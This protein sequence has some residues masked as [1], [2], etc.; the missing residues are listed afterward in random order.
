MPLS[1]Q[2][3][4]LPV[5]R[6]GLPHSSPSQAVA[7]LLKTTPALLAC[8]YLPRRSFREQSY[9]RSA[10]GFPGLIVDSSAERVYVQQAL[11]V[12][13]I[14]RLALAYL[15]DDAAHAALS[16]DDAAG[17]TE[18]LRS[19][20]AG[21]KGRALKSEL[22]GPISLGLQLTDE[23]QRPLAYEP[24]LLDALTQHL[25]LRAAWQ[26]AQFTGRAADSIL[27]LDEP[28]LDAFESPFCP[29]DLDLGL[30]LLEKV[31]AE[32]TGCRA[33]AVSGAAP[34]TALF[35]TSVE[36]IAFDAY[37]HSAPLLAASVALAAF[38]ERKG[39]IAWGLIPVDEY[40]LAQEN[41]ETLVVRFKRL[42][43]TLAAVGIAQERVLAASLIT[44]SGSLESLSV[45]V[46]EQAL[47]LCAEV[48]DEIR[49]LY[50]V[51]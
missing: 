46:A 50:D 40:L 3:A 15:Q 26:S 6:G 34:W 29:L 19:I 21:F 10:I 51:I 4:C 31:F 33:L 28:F 12:R 37:H 45:A 9:I 47:A 39:M 43:D 18:V 22:L 1:F 11:A 38:L 24:V 23:D 48:S 27:C 42:L 41:A 32:I 16:S 30:E 35:E 25:A 36:L 17:M 49:T 14:D 13:E 20:G 8:P 7:L 5:A 44:T 2:P